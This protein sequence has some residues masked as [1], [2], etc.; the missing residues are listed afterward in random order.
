MG[1]IAAIA[2]FFFSI[3]AAAMSRQL[4]DEFKA[5]VPWLVER[6]LQL[7]I[8]QLPEGQ[9]QRFDEE[10][11]SHINEVPGNVGKLLAALG[12]LSAARKMS[13]I[14]KI[15]PEQAMVVD[16][17]KRIL[18]LAV[19]SI[20]LILAGPLFAVLALAIRLDSAG[21]VLIASER[22]GLNGRK[23]K[24]YKFRTTHAAA[25]TEE[26]P[27]HFDGATCRPS[28][29]GSFLRFTALDELPVII[30][31]LK[32]EMAIVG[33]RPVRPDFGEELSN[34]IPR[35]SERM[36]VKP[37]IT[38]WAAVHSMESASEEAAGAQLSDDLYYV[39]NRSLWLDF[40]ILIRTMRVALR[41]FFGA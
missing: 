27:A 17:V 3:L 36:N 32:G 24:I 10:W 8:A 1:L 25:K 23:F 12:F 34:T 35:Y 38:G 9:R 20:L 21:P 19:S 41:R 6:L 13:L 5:W 2:R 11:R 15:G 30:N 7:A 14:L 31:V 37:G 18:D 39:E 28:R 16:I 26:R 33:P 40:L 4:T 29:L 22:V